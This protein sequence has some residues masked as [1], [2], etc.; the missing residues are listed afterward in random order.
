MKTSIDSAAG[1]SRVPRLVRTAL[2]SALVSLAL[3][4]PAAAQERM[5][6]GIDASAATTATANGMPF[7]YGSIWAGAWNQKWGWGGI[8]TQ[9]QTARANNLVPVIHWWYWG[10]DISPTCVEQGCQDRY[11]QVWKDKATWTRLSNE[12]ADLTTRVMGPGSTAIIIVETEFN[13]NGIETYEAFDGYLAEQA[14]I[15]HARNQQVVIGFGNWGQSQWT[16]FDRAAAAADYLGT[17]V[18]YSSVRDAS[19]YM[20]GAQK[21]IDGA[22]VLKGLFGKPCFVTDFAFSSYPEPAYEGYQDFVVRDI[23]SRLADLKAAG[24]KGMVWRMLSDDPAFDTANYHGMAERYWGLRRANGTQKL[25][26]TSFVQGLRAEA[27]GT[28]APPAPLAAPTGITATAAA[29]QV[30]VSWSLVNGATGYNV[31]RSTTSGGP[32]TIVAAGV[33]GTAY[34]NTGLVNGTTYYYV[35]SARSATA[36]SANS[37]QASAMPAAAPPPATNTISVW[38]PT[39]NATLSGT[40]PFKSLVDG[41]ALANYK[42]YWRVDGGVENLMGDS[43]NGGAHKE[44]SVSVKS[45]TWRGRGPYTIT[46]VAKNLQGTVIAQRN[47]TIYVQ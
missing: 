31:K 39:Q 16:R 46:F 19:V 5:R 24:V 11:Q 27:S 41:M 6:F 13:K 44:A 34:T 40:Q 23:F 43:N 10:D 26:F 42:M 30:T 3:V 14:A 33:T 4:S 18:L 7:T 17:Q 22:L 28:P 29:T 38:W 45:W 35:V 12:L 21:L 32:Y 37:A 8:E 15:F 1:V 2:W 20:S 36:E 47:V 9:L 25:A